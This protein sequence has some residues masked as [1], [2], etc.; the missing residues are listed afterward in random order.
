MVR[1]GTRLPGQGFWVDAPGEGERR[2]DRADDAGLAIQA[3]LPAD[4]VDGLDA[5]A[6]R[7][8]EILQL[9]LAQ[10]PGRP[11]QILVR[12]LVEVQA[13]DHRQGLGSRVTGQIRR[14]LDEGGAQMTGAARPRSRKMKGGSTST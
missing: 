12:L 13:A 7:P 2:A 1:Q 14:L 10:L 9:V 11:L 3:R 8:Q 4:G 6:M 5:R